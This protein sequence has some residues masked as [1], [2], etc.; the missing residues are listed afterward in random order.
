MTKDRGLSKEF[1]VLLQIYEDTVINN[2]AVYFT[3]LLNETGFSRVELHRC[4]DRLYDRLMID[5]KPASL[6]D[7][8]KAVCFTISKDFLSYTKGL[9]N[10][11]EKKVDCN[12]CEDIK[13]M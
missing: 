10:S 3:K 9:Y 5:Q 11:T 13:G 8:T 4:L 6:K 7:G 1:E 12:L 2:D